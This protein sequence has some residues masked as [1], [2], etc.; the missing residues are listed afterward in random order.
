MEPGIA[1]L[2]FG[3]GFVLLML[4]IYGILCWVDMPDFG[5]FSDDDE[6]AVMICMLATCT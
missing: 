1:A 5:G 3:G 6:E 4:A 2:V